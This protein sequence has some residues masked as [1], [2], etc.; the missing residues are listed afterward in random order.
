MTNMRNSFDNFNSNEQND[1]SSG[2][3]GSSAND[4]LAQLSETVNSLDPLTA[5]EKSLNEQV[6]F[7]VYFFVISDIVKNSF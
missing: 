1:S 6:R 7:F 2:G 5:I 4:S 3:G